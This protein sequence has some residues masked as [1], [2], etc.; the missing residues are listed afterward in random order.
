MCENEVGPDVNTFVI[1]MNNGVGAYLG[2]TPRSQLYMNAGKVATLRGGAFGSVNLVTVATT[3]E[4]QGGIIQAKAPWDMVPATDCHNYNFQSKL[5]WLMQTQGSVSMIWQS[6]S[7]M[8]TNAVV[9][10][11]VALDLCVIQVVFL[12]HSRICCIP[13]HMSKTPLG[14]VIL[15]VAYWGNANLQTLTTYLAQN[16]SPG[17]P[18]RWYALCGPALMASI[19]GIMTG[20]LVQ[21]WF[22]PRVVTQTW[23]LLAFSAANWILVFVLEGFVYPYQSS[24]VSNKCGLPTSTNCLRFDAISHTDPQHLHPLL[25]L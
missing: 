16:P 12:R 8:F 3:D 11:L 15:F 17:I 1:R 24:N 22:N 6:D 18:A 10:F 14:A 20:T 7:L 2:V 5:G 13:V 23:L 19:V 21:T 9:L 4:Y 25:L